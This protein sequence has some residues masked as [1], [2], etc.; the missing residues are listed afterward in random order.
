MMRRCPP[1]GQEHETTSSSFV[2]DLIDHVAAGRDGSR[3]FLRLESPDGLERRKWRA[4]HYSLRWPHSI[5]DRL[6]NEWGTHTMISHG[7]SNGVTHSTAADP[8]QTSSCGTPLDSKSLLYPRPG[9]SWDS[10]KRGHSSQ[11][12]DQVDG[13]LRAGLGQPMGEQVGKGGFVERREPRL[14][15]RHAVF[16]C[17]STSCLSLVT[18][19]STAR[20]P[21]S[22]R[23]EHHET[24]C[25]CARGV[26][27]PDAAAATAEAVVA[28]V[29]ATTSGRTRRCR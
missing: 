22:E 19:R 16:A 14:L 7:A 25:A 3:E 23:S 5:G 17:L 11:P 21:S 26:G 9:G 27:A 15:S 24:D 20:A 18:R 10:L 28:G 6:I 8:K 2:D 12:K 13:A 4:C 29:T 1:K